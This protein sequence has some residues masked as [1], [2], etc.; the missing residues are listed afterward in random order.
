LKESVIRLNKPKTLAAPQEPLKGDL[1]S[2]TIA[3]AKAA[4]DKEEHPLGGALFGGLNLNVQT[5][6]ENTPLPDEKTLAKLD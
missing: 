2:R 3:L 4:K 5:G 6:L 1:I